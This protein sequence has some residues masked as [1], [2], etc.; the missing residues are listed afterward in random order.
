[1]HTEIYCTTQQV[2]KKLGAGVIIVLTDKQQ[3]IRQFGWGLNLTPPGLATIQTARL[4]L[5]SI[6]PR[7]RRVDTILYIND[8]NLDAPE[9]KSEIE[10]LK[11]WMGYY[12]KLVIKDLTDPKYSKLVEKLAYTAAKTQKNYDSSTQDKL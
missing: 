9:W 11:Q 1:M 6:I 3:H 4:A 7:F 2:K 12:P 10:L 5:C 8:L